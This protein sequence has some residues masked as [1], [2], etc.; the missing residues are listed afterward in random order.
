MKPPTLGLSSGH[1]IRLDFQ[2]P[3]WLCVAGQSLPEI[4]SLSYSLCPSPAPAVSVSLKINKLNFFLS[5]R[6][7]FQIFLTCYPGRATVCL[8]LHI[9][10]DAL[11]ILLG[12]NSQ[13]RAGLSSSGGSRCSRLRSRLDRRVRRWASPLAARLL[14]VLKRLRSAGASD[15]GNRW[16]VPPALGRYSLFPKEA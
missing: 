7:W 10:M 14:S 16:F 9:Q 2:V 4:L 8:F 15:G 3:L 6:F 5:S 13:T 11:E 1:G 12:H